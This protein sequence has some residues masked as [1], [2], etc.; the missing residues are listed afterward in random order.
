[1]VE[2]YTYSIKMCVTLGGIAIIMIMMAVQLNL[3]EIMTFKNFL[4]YS[5]IN[6]LFSSLFA[7]FFSKAIRIRRMLDEKEEK[8]EV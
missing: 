4:I 1:M 6:S 2:E 3:V 8:K 5:V 7:M